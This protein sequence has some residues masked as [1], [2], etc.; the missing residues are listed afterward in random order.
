MDP[1]NKAAKNKLLVCGQEIKKQKQ[2]EKRTFAHM[3]DKFA[4]IDAKREEEV[5][6]KRV[7]KTSKVTCHKSK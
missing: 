2:K 6:T 7:S 5:R 4:R 1:E 3:F